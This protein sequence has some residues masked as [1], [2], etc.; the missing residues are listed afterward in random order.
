[1]VYYNLLLFAGRLCR[2]RNR[3]FDLIRV[4]DSARTHGLIGMHLR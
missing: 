1:M 3:K 4:I 2:L